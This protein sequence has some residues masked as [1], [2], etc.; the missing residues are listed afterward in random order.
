MRTIRQ[1]IALDGH[2]I[3][4]PTRCPFGREAFNTDRQDQ[5]SQRRKTMRTHH[6]SSS[7]RLLYG[8]ISAKSHA[9]VVDEGDAIELIAFHRNYLTDA[10]EPGRS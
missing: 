10:A 5:E 1:R 9:W 2:M 8:T 7:T 6:P 4:E 3:I